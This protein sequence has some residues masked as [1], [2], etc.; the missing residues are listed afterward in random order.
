MSWWSRLT[1]VFQSERLALDLDDEIQF[2]IEERIRER[3]ASGMTREAAASEV[4]RRFGNP[5]RLRETSRDVKLM[6]W[7][8]SLVRDL[9]LGLRMLRKNAIVTIAAV[10][11]LGFA[12]GACVAAYSLVDALI[13]R[14]LPV[15]D[16]DRLVYLAFT[17]FRPEQPEAETFNDPLFVSLRDAS[18]DR[19]DLFAMSTQV[20]LPAIFESSGEKE[21][22]RTQYISGDAFDLLGV[23]G[24]IGRLIK[25]EDDVPATSIAV[26]S[27]A[28]WISRFG[29]SPSAIGRRFTINNRA[30]QIAGVTDARFI[31]V[32]PGRPTSLWLPYASYNP[33]AFGNAQFNWFRILGRLKDDVRPE[34]AQ[35]ALQTVFTSFRRERQG[36]FDP[37]TSS[38]DRERL[39][40]APIYVRPA[41]NGPSPLRHQFGRSLWILTVIAGLV[42]LIAGSNVGNLFLARAAAR[43]REMA[44]R[45][46]I[47]AGRG[48]LIQQLL[49]ESAIV[50]VAACALG[51]MFATVAAPSVV[52]MLTAPGDPVQLDL[53][54]GWKLLGFAGGLA[55]LTTLLFGITPALR[56]SR[57]APMTTLNTGGGRSL[58]RTGMFRPFVAL[59]LAFGMVV[60]FV[61]G[62]LALSFARL[63]NVDPGFA[64]SNVLLLDVETTRRIDGSQQRT[65]FFN[66]LDRLR[67]V[68]GVQD[69]AAAEYNPLG[70]AWTAF[71]RLPGK[72]NE[73][74]ETTMSPVSARFF[75]TMRMPL[76]RGRTFEPKDMEANAAPSVVVNESF[77]RR[78]FGEQMPVGRGFEGR[79]NMS[80]DTPTQ[81]N[82]VGIVADARYDLR[83]PAAPT[84]FM[85]LRTSGTI[86]VRTAAL[87]AALVTRLR[88]E[89]SGTDSQFRVTSITTQSAVLDRTMLRER[90][91][92]NLATFF[93][94]VGL[95]LLA[96]G[97]YGVLSYSV[98]HRTREIGIRL[99]LGAG[100]MRVIRT[101]VMDFGSVVLIGV[102]SG[103][104]GGAYLSRFVEALLFDVQ[105]Q[106][107]L[108]F[109]LPLGTLLLMVLLAALLP[110]LR[111]ARVDPVIALRSE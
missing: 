10:V 2:H 43:E 69:V 16:P 40:H 20:M 87:P 102:L 41:A 5:L 95:V 86:H 94:F 79:F 28:F 91:L 23:Q 110:A 49:I 8:D 90:L 72:P 71:I 96:V 27:H 55:L 19:V 13:L 56:A 24:A 51:L 9:N 11:S 36:L 3:I 26:I 6:P 100:P 25:P 70:R 44:L 97:F 39:I 1:N 107:L 81:Y 14:P 106:N 47:G 48:R 85:P 67:L 31:G 92:A 52:G 66:L 30:Y 17:T 82:I 7:L 103:L 98:V 76:V 88:A 54:M 93:A 34:V 60:L 78:Y 18:H 29:G 59:Q 45:L 109:A 22:V 64:T 37:G 111:A 58:T 50:A 53:Q 80:N 101:V 84:I 104:A 21:R 77:A 108:S 63:S 46:S 73:A 12:L 32:E 74:I 75:E 62:L 99:A 105:P 68:P 57:L 83:K 61:G 35:S 38:T 33:R 89:I 42:L 65:A 15:R 4:A